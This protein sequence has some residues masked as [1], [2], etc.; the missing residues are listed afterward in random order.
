MPSIITAKRYRPRQCKLEAK[1]DS[2]DDEN[3]QIS[4]KPRIDINEA[5][6][7]NSGQ[8]ITTNIFVQIHDGVM[9]ING[10]VI[11]SKENVFDVHLK[12]CSDGLATA[13]TAHGNLAND[14]ILRSNLKANIND[15]DCLTDQ[16]KTPITTVSKFSKPLDKMINNSWRKC[17]SEN[18]AR[19][20]KISINEIVM[21]KVSGF[22][23]WPAIVLDFIN[24]RRARVEF[25]GADSHEKIG[26]VD[27]NE[28][29]PFKYSTDVILPLLK[30]DARNFK[31][32]VREA[33]IAA[34]IPNS[35]SMCK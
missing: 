31:K 1:M 30:R 28:I 11:P 13:A 22:S 25:F 4:K 2:F 35:K 26:L 12:L 19:D 32:A 33:E 20:Q 29:T 15:M 18:T 23:A 7:S 27:L 21:A 9:H 17:K 16:T 3:S 10:T 34:G 6:C 5:H 14:R 24:K 8:I